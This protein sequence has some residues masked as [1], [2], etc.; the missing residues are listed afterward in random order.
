M[1]IHLKSTVLGLVVAL[2]A[3][4]AMAEASSPPTDPTALAKWCRSQIYKRY[5]HRGADGKRH[6]F[7][8]F[9]AR[10]VNACMTSGGKTL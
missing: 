10:S 5:S 9:V 8:E 7:R 3:S 1:S 6:L 2:A 4:S